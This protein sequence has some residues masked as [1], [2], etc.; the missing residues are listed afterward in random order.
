MMAG[1]TLFA[2]VAF[3]AALSALKEGFPIKIISGGTDGPSSFWV[4]RPGRR[5][6][7][8]RTSRASASSIAGP[9]R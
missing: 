7:R 3:P 6:T 8:R 2:E 9:S 1:D 5:S 4:T